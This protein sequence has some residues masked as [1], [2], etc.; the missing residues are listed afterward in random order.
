MHLRRTFSLSRVGLL[1]CLGALL[2]ALL[3]ACAAPQSG[4]LPTAVPVPPPAEL[5]LYSWA[6]YMPQ[7]VLDGYEAETGTHVVY[8]TYDSQDEAV[9]A[10]RAGN[11]RFDVAVIANDWIPSLRTAGALAELERNNLPNFSNVSHEFRNLFFD[12]ENTYTVPYL[13]GTTGLLVRSDLVEKPVTRW[14]D[15]WDARFT[16]KIAARPIPSE[17]FGAALLALGNDLNTENSDELR[18]ALAR[19]EEIKPSLHYVPVET[20][21]ALEPLLQGDVLVMIGWNGDAL[22]ARQENPAV[23]YVMPAEGALAWVDNLVVSAETDHQAAAESFI[24]YILRPQVS[25]AISETYFYPSAN[26][27]ANQHVTEALRQDPLLFPRSADIANL[28][29]YFPQSADVEQLYDQLWQQF[30][31]GS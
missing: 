27:A 13:W 21:A 26:E 12:P 29:F 5:V 4:A 19:L 15:L 7:S 18:L 6:E 17:L 20:G 24:N 22:A 9:A 25:A 1:L 8:L 23:A 14:A 16:G 28:N 11:V 10:I 31:P 3:G 2:G 30:S